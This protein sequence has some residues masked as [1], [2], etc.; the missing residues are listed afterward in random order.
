MTI[1]GQIVVDEHYGVVLEIV[2]PPL[3]NQHGERVVQIPVQ[4]LRRSIR[5]L[6]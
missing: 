3:A 6:A 2:L 4:Q 1:E 5:C